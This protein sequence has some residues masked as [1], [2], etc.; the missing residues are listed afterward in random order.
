MAAYIVHIFFENKQLMY[1]YIS[2]SAYIDE[3]TGYIYIHICI[4]I[5]IKISPCF[6]CSITPPSLQIQT[7]TTENLASSKLATLNFFLRL[8]ISLLPTV[9]L[10]VKY[11]VQ[12]CTGKTLLSLRIGVILHPGWQWQQ[13]PATL[14]KSHV[15]LSH[16]FFHRAD[17]FKIWSHA[18]TIGMIRICGCDDEKSSL[19]L[20]REIYFFN[21]IVKFQ[22]NRL[23]ILL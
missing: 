9:Q 4:Y 2:E 15:F 20:E 23:I 6:C 22:E 5:H 11:P 1:E 13:V 12:K 8:F 14:K 21:E 3:R 10:E 19:L 16:F 17:D 7:S 18:L